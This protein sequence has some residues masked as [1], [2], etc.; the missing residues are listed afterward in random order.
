MIG[1]DIAFKKDWMKLMNA[2]K[3]DV[4][5]ERFLSLV[6][7]DVPG[8][9]IYTDASCMFAGAELAE[10]CAET[11]LS[12]F[13]DCNRDDYHLWNYEH[14]SFIIE[15]SNKYEFKI[16]ENLANGLPQ[17]LFLLLQMDNLEK[18]VCNKSGNTRK[19][20]W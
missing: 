13:P 15:E 19:E 3:E 14:L 1:K 6:P 10:V 17:Q 7:S 20:S 9:K 16:S 2:G 4:M 11:V 18:P 8:G 12:V 5:K